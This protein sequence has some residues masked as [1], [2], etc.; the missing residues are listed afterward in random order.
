MADLYPPKAQDARKSGM[1]KLQCMIQADGYMA[2][3]RVL[4]QS[5]K[6]Y[7][8]GVATAT[9]FVNFCHVDPATIIGGIQPGDYK[10]FVYKWQIG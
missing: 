1:A 3:C 7:G 5:P 10:I 4:D 2:K 9:A 8:F 6:D